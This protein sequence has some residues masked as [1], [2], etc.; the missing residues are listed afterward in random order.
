MKFSSS[1]LLAFVATSFAPSLVQAEFEWAGTFDLSASSHVWSMEATDGVYPDASMKLVFYSSD[2]T[3]SDAIEEL[4]EGAEGLIDGTCDDLPDGGTVSG[5]PSDG[6]CYNFVVGS[7]DISLFTIDTTGLTGLVVFTEHHPVEFEATQ[8]YF[9]TADGEDVEPVAVEDGGEGHGHDHGHEDHGDESEE[10]GEKLGMSCA[11]A[12]EEYGYVIDCLDTTAMADALALLKSS[13]CA[14]DCSSTVCQ[15]NWLIVQ[16]HHDYCDSD[17]IPQEVEADFHDF[18]TACKSC[19]IAR[20][21]VD[22]A[23]ACPVVDCE[24]GSGNEAYAH[25]VDHGCLQDCSDAECE[26]DFLILTTVHDTCDHDALTTA[27]EEGKP[28]HN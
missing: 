15:E 18:D 24:D 3:D 26:A 27:S 28:A 5:I 13:A 4:E 22:G 17:A 10:E 2:H 12:A 1:T 16:T 14:S 7:E 9:Q 6:I 23:A 21:A 11:C 20:A 25:L 8:H 19:D